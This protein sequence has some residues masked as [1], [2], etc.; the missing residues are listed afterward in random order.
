MIGATIDSLK[1]QTKKPCQW[2]V[3]DG[4]SNDKTIE[5]VIDSR[6]EININI[7]QEKDSGVYDAWNKA[8]SLISGDWVLFLGAGDRLATET[9][10]EDCMPHLE[11]SID[12]MLVYGNV[13]KESYHSSE[14]RSPID[15][16]GRPRMPHHQAIFHRSLIYLEDCQRYDESFKIAADYKLNIPYLLRGSISYV[17]VDICRVDVNGISSDPKNSYLTWK[18]VN[19]ACEDCGIK[20][21]HLIKVLS[22]LKLRANISIHRMRQI[23]F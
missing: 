9:T 21:N 18:E 6:S 1:A 11:G 15:L 13:F 10:L 19:K 14:L 5:T 16:M 3:V 7:I 4:L 22:F 23:L 12:R 17:D 2:I 20:L 8:L